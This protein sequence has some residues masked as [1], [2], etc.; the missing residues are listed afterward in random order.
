LVRLVK[1]VGCGGKQN[2]R[3]V[4][5]AFTLIDLLVA[6][7]VIAVLISLM[8]PTLAAVKETT[9]K[10]V[11]TSNIRQLGLGMAMYA[12]D[13]RGVVPWSRNYSKSI[14][15][16]DLGFT[17][18]QLM[19]VRITW[20][21]TDVWDGL[22][23]LYDRSYCR[24]QGVFYCPSCPTD[25]RVENFSTGWLGGQAE[26]MTNYQYRGGSQSGQRD[27]NKMPDRIGMICDGLASGSDFN[28][29]VGANVV[30]SDLSVEWYDDTQR[31]MQQLLP[32]FYSQPGAKDS[33]LQAWQRIDD[34]LFKK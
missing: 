10:V 6:M 16:Q 33:L 12:D 22:G 19:K 25:N 27:L 13:E 18:D 32:G 31:R 26:V 28:H 7:S 24:A 8:I 5:R 11:C 30:G 29:G 20:Q 21:P 9:R 14:S 1:L 17:P 4:R 2:E 23:L 3:T 34:Q 15:T